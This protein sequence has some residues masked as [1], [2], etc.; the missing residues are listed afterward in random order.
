MKFPYGLG[1]DAAGNVY[2]ADSQND[3]IRGI[4]PSGAV[5]TLAGQLTPGHA[6]GLG[7]N[8]SFS[9]PEGIAID[10]SGNLYIGDNGN[11]LIRRITPA[12]A[13]T[14][15][16][17]QLTAGHADNLIGTSASFNGPAGV[18]VDGV[19][20]IYVADSNN[21]LI[22]K[23]S[24]NG[25]VTTFAG[26]LTSGHANQ[27]GTSSSFSSPNGIAID[28]WGT[29]YVADSYNHLIR[30]IDKS[31]NVTTLA[32]QISGGFL[33]ATGTAAKFTYPNWVGC[34]PTGNVYVADTGNNRI[35]KIQ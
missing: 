22:R 1:V 32:G 33:D 17:G 24:P 13:V 2:V 9:G 34:D 31:A 23:V 7:S 3:T 16:A 15:L 21:N 20:N 19:G 28:A 5:T 12:S 10:S 8:A 18:A 14:T 27:Q 30:K 11:N 35:R 29:L 4:S 25:A 26:Q 6:D